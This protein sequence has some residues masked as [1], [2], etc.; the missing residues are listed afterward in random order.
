MYRSKSSLKIKI[1]LSMIGSMHKIFVH[2]IFKLQK[3]ALLK[4]FS[5]AF[6]K[7]RILWQRYQID[8]WNIACKAPAQGD[9]FHEIAKCHARAH[10][11][12]NNQK[13]C[14]YAINPQVIQEM[15]FHDPKVI[16]VCGKN[17]TESR[18][19]QGNLKMNMLNPEAH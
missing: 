11:S 7:N 17:N 10:K 16:R 6:S 5:E 14:I 13:C 8:Q 3:R 4:T 18:Q 15:P 19:H 2:K 9:I 1:D 12:F